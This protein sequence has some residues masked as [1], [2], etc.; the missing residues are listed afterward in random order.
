MDHTFIDDDAAISLTPLRVQSGAQPQRAC[1]T[2]LG[3]YWVG[4]RHEI[5]S[6][7]LVRLVTEFGVTAAS[8]RIALNRLTKRGFLERAKSGR[9]TS[10]SLTD[11][12]VA[13]L[14]EGAARILGFGG[15][16]VEWG[17]QWCCVAFSVPEIERHVRGSLRSRLRFAGF[18]PLYDGLWICPRDR[19][20]RALK[21]ITALQVETATVFN[22]EVVPGG[23]NGGAPQSAWNLSEIR[24]QYDAF[25]RSHSPARK[26]LET[27][28]FSPTQALVTRHSIVDDWLLLSFADPELPDVLLPSRWPR[29][30]ARSIMLEVYDGLA[31]L[32]AARVRTILSESA[33]GLVEYVSPRLSQPTVRHGPTDPS[34]PS[35]RR[36]RQARPARDH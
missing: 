33:P 6:A 3:D 31:S 25:I 7:T 32:A 34:P 24:S 19:A 1:L 4:K 30:E 13:F 2:L 18:A 23:P 35:L 20:D 9:N 10:Y 8:A 11:G 36:D 16:Y 17:G 5:P 21:I 14:E 28:R 22:A 12:A 27:G 15:P 29:D 26:Q